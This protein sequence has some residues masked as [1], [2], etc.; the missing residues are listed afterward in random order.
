MGQ[1]SP[2]TWIYTDT[3]IRTESGDLVCDDP[4]P[5][6]CDHLLCNVGKPKVEL[7]DW[8][9]TDSETT[10]R[11]KRRALAMLEENVEALKR[12]PLREL[13]LDGLRIAVRKTM[14]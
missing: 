4:D 14:P 1:G 6:G 12:M 5:T 3:G 2:E 11:Q 9:G 8:R 13:D 10:T 7:T